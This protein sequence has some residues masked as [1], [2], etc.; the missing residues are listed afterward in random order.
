VRRRYEAQVARFDEAFRRHGAFFLISL[1]LTPFVPFW[2]V[3]LAMGL[4]P[5]RTSTFWW[6]GQLGMLPATCVFVFAGFQVP[7]L[8]QLEQQGV[9]DVLWP[10]P[11][12]ALSLLALLPW[13]GRFVAVR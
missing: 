10:G 7:T 6:V 12:L 2:L 13:V 1:R 11:V 9:W 5:I 3:N 4:T 8:G